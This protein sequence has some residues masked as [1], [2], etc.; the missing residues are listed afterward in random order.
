[1]PRQR[2]IRTPLILF[3]EG[4]TEGLFLGWIKQVYSSRLVDKAI[5][6]GNGNGGSAGSVLLELEKKHLGIGAPETPALVL[7]DADKGLDAEAEERLKQYKNIQIV[8]AEPQCL[9]GLL[10][11]LLDDLPPKGQQTSDTL[12]KYFQDEY[13]GSRQEVRKNFKMKRQALFP[14]PLLDSKIK[15]HTIL[16]KIADFLGI[17]TA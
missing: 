8:F 1:M 5:T 17:T 7:I 13:L 12:K 2:T 14:K 6:V 3:G 15:Q 10:L 4:P 11:D 16:R 9:E